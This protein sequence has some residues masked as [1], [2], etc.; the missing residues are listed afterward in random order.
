MKHI[1]NWESVVFIGNEWSTLRYKNIAEGSLL[2]FKIN[3][4]GSGYCE[5]ECGKDYEVDYKAGKIKRTEN[6]AIGDYKNSPFYGCEV[7]NHEPYCGNWGNYPFTVYV[8]YEFYEVGNTLVEDEAIRITAINGTP[9]INQSRFF[10]KLLK[11]EE[12]NYM[13]AGDSISTGC[14]AILKE[15][16]YFCRFAN[17][18]ER[19]TGGKVNVICKAVGGENSTKAASHFE[20]DVKDAK[21]DLVTISLGINDMCC[22]G[23]TQDSP[24]E[25]TLEEFHQ[26]LS[27]M[28]DTAHRIGAEVILI[29]NAVPNPCWKFTSRMAYLFPEEMRS[30]AKEY[31]LPIADNWKLWENELSNGKTLS[32]L[33]LN[34]VNHPTTYGH[35]LYAQMLF[36]L[37]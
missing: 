30:V 9:K 5:L 10:Q 25:I 16:S 6:S 1:Q 3:L 11:G 32:D 4:D 8:N 23:E 35:S 24:S 26:N 21:P 19:V 2:M 18:L 37:I 29:T 34:D 14:E 15:Q 33:L 28:I 17:K 36:T 12:I 7:F 31:G 27:F 13:V 22:H 20:A